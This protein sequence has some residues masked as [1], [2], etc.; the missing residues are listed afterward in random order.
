MFSE[1]K[2]QEGWTYSEWKE[3]NDRYTTNR[4]DEYD[5]WESKNFDTTDTW[6]QSGWIDFNVVEEGE[7]DTCPSPQTDS[8]KS[9]TG[10]ALFLK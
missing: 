1:G 9:S 8:D 5:Q 7:C 10:R 3:W 2:W 4:W 6:E